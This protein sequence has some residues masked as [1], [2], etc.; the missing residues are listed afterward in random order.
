MIKQFMLPDTPRS[1]HLSLVALF[2]LL[3]VAGAKQV[4][5]GKIEVADLPGNSAS[6]L[7]E[8]ENTIVEFSINVGTSQLTLGALAIDSKTGL[9]TAS[10]HVR[11][12]QASATNDVA[13]S[14]ISIVDTVPAEDRYFHEPISPAA[15]L[16]SASHDVGADLCFAN[17]SLVSRPGAAEAATLLLFIPTL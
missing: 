9:L 10:I 7:S 15:L 16:V 1:F 2:S 11:I 14:S 3:V 12:W 17:Q 6:V 8:P 5:A 13:Q 4:Q